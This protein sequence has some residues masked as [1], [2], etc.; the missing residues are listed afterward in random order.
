[1][2]AVLEGIKVLELCEVFQGP[3]AGQILGD[4]GADV[5]KI[6][7]PGRGDSLRHSDTVANERGEMGS[8]F[9]AVNRNK[10]SICLDLKDDAER[11]HFLRLVAQ[12]DVVLHNYRPG[13]MEKLGCGYADL[14]AINPRLVYAAASGFGAT[15]PLA[16]MAGQD[17]LIQ[18][19]SGIAWKTTACAG[20]PTF[21]N[22]PLADYTSGVLM[23]QG[24]LLALLERT[25]SGQGQQVSMSLFSALVAMQS[26]EAA[27]T[28][29]YGYETRWFERAL[30]FTAEAADG[31]L[32]VIGFFRDNPLKLICEAM[33]LED[34][35]S[36]AA[37]AGKHEQATHRDEIA[38]LLR[39]AFRRYSTE[40]AVRRLQAHGVLAAPILRFEETLAHAQT[41]ANG[42]IA[43][44]PVE[45]QQAMRV[46]A[47]PV[48]LSRTPAQVRRGP[49]HLGA[50]R[51]E[52]L[53]EP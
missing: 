52:I 32:T 5:V 22:V 3:L 12:A 1:M 11:A 6:E 21:I 25:R 40:E 44:V 29:N 2:S 4:Y 36:R 39:P 45:G 26:L 24:V 48:M 38:Q 37:W 47:H 18:S 10:R 19:I 43:T 51:G 9:A 31:W 27:S 33:G 35:S 50:H 46:L 16:A 49:P 7:R 34:L 30:N 23:A 14:A 20:E 53:G 42:L 15:G 17:F 13:V 8:Y 28:L 41:E